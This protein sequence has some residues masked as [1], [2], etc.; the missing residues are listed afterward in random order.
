MKSLPKLYNLSSYGLVDSIVLV[1]CGGTGGYIAPH[2]ARLI[3]S[4]SRNISITFVDGDVVES[5]N[6]IRQYFIEPDL[7]QNKAEVAAHRYSSAFGM[8]IQVL[9]EY[10]EEAQQILD[11][12][13]DGEE[14]ADSATILLGCVDNNKSRQVLEDTVKN[15]KYRPTFWIDCGNLELAGQIICG[16]SPSVI[17]KDQINPQTDDP[18]SYGSFS[19]PSVFE[20]YPDMR[21]NIGKFNSELSCAELAQ[22]APQNM[23]TNI[24]ASTV[25]MNYVRA[26]ISRQPLRSHGV[27]FSIDNVFATRLNTREN[28]ATIE[29][30]RRAQWEK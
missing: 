29:E 1:G 27:S 24:T 19:L 3:K 11:I 21:E 9:P 18:N 16:Y 30:S 20:V 4:L 5:K 7:N 10:V 2:L 13:R 17:A 14:F 28:L 12:V 6:L 22:S 23:M 15:L 26:I 8:E 25:A